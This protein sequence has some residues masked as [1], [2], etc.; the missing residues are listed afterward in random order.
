MISQALHFAGSARGDEKLSLKVLERL[1]RQRDQDARDRCA[2][3]LKALPSECF[4]IIDE[5]SMD[6]RTLRRRRGWAPRGQP[7]K[8]Y[9]I[10]EAHGHKLQSLVAAVNKD[11]F[12]LDACRLVEGGKWMP[13]FCFVPSYF[14]ATRYTRLSLLSAAPAAVSATVSLLFLRSGVDA[15][16]LATMKSC[17]GRRSA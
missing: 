5:S 16:A 7:A 14:V 11:G 10:F 8:L 4:V 9:E 3:V 2:D 13:L 12:I 15:Q 17:H 1:A 6:R